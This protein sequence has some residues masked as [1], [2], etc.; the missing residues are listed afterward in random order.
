[1]AVTF[2]SQAAK[3][4]RMRSIREGPMLRAH[5]REEA[6]SGAS[7]IRRMTPHW[8]RP[9]HEEGVFGVAAVD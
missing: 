5:V 6:K 7:R 3:C 2:G 8:P 4:V 1:M 9:I